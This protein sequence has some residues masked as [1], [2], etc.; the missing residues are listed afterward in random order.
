MPTSATILV[1]DQNPEVK[2]L[3]PV[4]KQKVAGSYYKD[5]WTSPQNSSCGAGWFQYTFYG[6]RIYVATLFV[7][8]SEFAVKIDD[9]DFIT[10]SGNGSFYSPQLSDG[11]HSITYAMGN[12]S[13]MPAFDYMSVT[14]GPS[15]P[16]EGKTIV[17]DDSVG[18]IAFS[19][20]WSKSSPYPP[21]FDYTS[22]LYQSTTQWTSNVG[23]TMQF[24]FEGSSVAVYGI[25]AYNTT[26]LRNITAN[27]TL[28]GVTQTRTITND[29]LS[30]LSMVELF[31][32]DVQA[33]NH[34]LLFNLTDIQGQRA[35]GIDF[36]AYNASFNSLTT[37]ATNSSGNGQFHLDVPDWAPKVGIAFASV[38]GF[39]FLL[40]LV[41]IFWQKFRKDR[42]F[43]KTYVETA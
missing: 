6:T 33:G 16:L 42:H 23:D 15:T 27:Y 12:L 37:P 8:P 36:V 43:G 17:V 4:L 20:N 31:R 11:K 40:T 18:S 9:G 2:Y 29:T 32:A 30:Y 1:D 28:D 38:A 13:V 34:S 35:L 39:A 21:S 7:K 24:Q 41:I 10:Q 3:C 5:T 25:V 26:S 22:T 14:A 19:G